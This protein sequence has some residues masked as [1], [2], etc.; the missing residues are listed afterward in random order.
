M[1][2]FHGTIITCDDNNTVANYLVERE[3]RIAY[4]GEK[5]P[6]QYEVV[7]PIELGNNVMIPAFVDTHMHY[8]GFSVLHKLFPINDT[9]SNAKILEQL[10]EYAATTKENIVVGFGATEFAVSEGHLILKE[11]MDV[12]CPEKPALIIKHDAHSGVANTMFINAVYSKIENLRG[13]NKT[14]GELKQEAFLAACEFLTHGFSTKKVIDSM[15]ETSD[16]LASRGI[17]L[18]CSA[19]GLGFIRD[20]D[21]DMERSVAKGLDNGMQIRAAYQTSNV[22]KISRKEMSRVVFANLDG[23]FAN[24]D[25][26]LLDNYCTI[27]NKGVSY[28]N[29]VDVQKF[30]INANRAGYQIALHA[31]GDAAFEQA[32]NAIAM[33]LEDYPRY[34]HRHIILHGSLPTEAALK[35]CAK[36]NI[37]ISAQPSMLSHLDGV[38]EYVKE[39]L[40]EDRAKGINPLKSINDMGIKVCFNSDAPASDPNPVMWIHDACNNKNP[41]Q[42]VSVYDALRMA[43]FN[44]AFSLFEEKERGSL[45]MGKSCDLTILDA[46]PYE[47]PKEELKNINVAEMY[48]KGKPY[49]RSRMGSMATMLRGMFPQ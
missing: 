16:F 24:Q 17:G 22:D 2:V 14:T 45:E 43:T 47:V 31:F 19:S 27:N 3:G 7:P 28:F 44:G 26:A 23:T 9:D 25:A 8:S 13:F 21:F 4:I 10:K 1:Q 36:Y 46:N 12:A 32:T 48:L 5:L 49:Q 41:E 39:M 34:D 42:S 37:M 20:Y 29:D 35:T 30:C 33:A 38:Y 15:V 11:Q 18:I 40:S 6:T